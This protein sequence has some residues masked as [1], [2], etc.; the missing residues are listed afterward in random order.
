MGTRVDAAKARFQ[1]AVQ[2]AGIFNGIRGAYEGAYLILPTLAEIPGLGDAITPFIGWLPE[3]SNFGGNAVLAGSSLFNALLRDKIRFGEKQLVDTIKGKFGLLALDTLTLATAGSILAAQ[4]EAAIAGVPP[5]WPLV[6]AAGDNASRTIETRISNFKKAEGLGGKFLSGLALI[7]IAGMG[8]YF[9]PY[10]QDKARFD[11][12]AAAAKQQ[13]DVVITSDEI[14]QLRSA[15]TSLLD[16][17]GSLLRQKSGVMTAQAERTSAA[18]LIS[19][20]DTL[21]KQAADLS[22]VRKA[23]VNSLIPAGIQKLPVVPQLIEWNMTAVNNMANW[24][25]PKEEAVPTMLTIT[26]D[27]ETKIRAAK[28]QAIKAQQNA[29]EQSLSE[30]VTTPPKPSVKPTLTSSAKSEVAP[31]ESVQALGICPDMKNAYTVLPTKGK[32]LGPV[33]SA[34]QLKANGVKP[35]HMIVWE[36]YYKQYSL[37]D[38]KT[39]GSWTLAQTEKLTKLV[40]D[41]YKFNQDWAANQERKLNWDPNASDPKQNLTVGKTVCFPD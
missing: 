4:V 25:R 19:E 6:V 40:D 39:I 31:P 1:E 22:R 21:E 27:V 35:L 14:R 24:A 30:P 20:A 32:T 12:A 3:P 41:V 9:G 17:A 11:S 8:F 34:A 33:D 38:I 16:R 28:A 15:S 37:P 23:T 13:Y 2:P 29:E 18:S 36:H 5:N 10:A 26:G 7:A